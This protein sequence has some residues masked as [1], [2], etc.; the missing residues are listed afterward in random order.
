MSEE[1]SNDAE[2]LEAEIHSLQAE[3]DA[4][5]RLQQEYRSNYGKQIQDAMCVAFSRSLHA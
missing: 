3:V 5:Q 4:L 2:M 1:N